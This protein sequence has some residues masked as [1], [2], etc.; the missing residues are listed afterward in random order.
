VAIPV[1]DKPEPPPPPQKEPLPPPQ[2]PPKPSWHHGHR[3]ILFLAVLFVLGL[4]VYVGWKIIRY[5]LRA[6]KVIEDY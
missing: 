1:P 3:W 5:W 6:M 4:G 2:H